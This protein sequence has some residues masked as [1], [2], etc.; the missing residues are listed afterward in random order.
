MLPLVCCFTSLFAGLA[1]SAG[2]GHLAYRLQEANNMTVAVKDVATMGPSLMFVVYPEL[3]TK[4]PI[5]P[6]WA[7]LFFLMLIN[8]G[9]D[10]QVR[11]AFP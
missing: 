4:I 1:I 10:T 6:L 5:S 8:V 3:L 2:L 9:L 7:V 11:L